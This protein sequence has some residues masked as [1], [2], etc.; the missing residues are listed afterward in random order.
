MEDGSAIGAASG[1]WRRE[2]QRIIIH[3][4]DDASNGDQNYVTITADLNEM[5]T[6]LRCMQSE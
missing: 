6:K 5:T 1:V 2:G 3:S 4:L